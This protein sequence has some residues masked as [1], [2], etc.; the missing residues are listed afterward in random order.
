MRRLLL[1]VLLLL[2]L[3]PAVAEAVW[4]TL[5]PTP[6][7]ATYDRS[8]RVMLNGVRLFYATAGHGPPVLLLHGGLANS[9]HWGH[10]VAALRRAHQVI[11][12]DSRGHGR[13][14]RD[15]RPFGYHLMADDVVALLDHLELPRADVV[16]WSDG[17][18]IGLDLALRHP[19]R[20]GRIFAFAANV[21]TDGVI[22]NAD[23]NPTFAAYIAR[24]GREYAR[25][26]PTPGD[27]DAFLAQIG[28]MWATQPNW[29]DAQ[30][31]GIRARVQVVDGDHD[32]AIRRTHTEAMA[33]AIPG[34][35]LL[36]LPNASH[37]A[38]LQ[39]PVLFNAAMLHFLDAP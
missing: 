21:R 2:P 23:R 17:A 29:T 27:Y 7:P 16:G 39:D 35:G 18:I 10:Q 32:E 24:A 25:L 6:P 19:G 9:D 28:R 1:A 12:M 36:I 8:A 30:L 33:A 3:R 31:R 38:F 20:V 34:A 26:S 37:F 14:A 5:P 4:Q 11:V 22:P 13:S 15:A